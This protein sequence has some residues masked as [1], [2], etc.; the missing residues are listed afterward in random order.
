MHP[1]GVKPDSHCDGNSY[2]SA[3]AIPIKVYGWSAIN[4][5]FDSKV[6]VGTA[7][8]ALFFRKGTSAHPFCKDATLSVISSGATGAGRLW[9]Y[10]A[11][12]LCGIDG[13]TL[14]TDFSVHVNMSVPA[15]VCGFSTYTPRSKEIC[16]QVGV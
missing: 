9:Y 10:K 7:K 6:C 8:I 1:F 13:E 14:S 15:W 11:H 2:F 12:Q 3:S 16:D 5:V 4:G